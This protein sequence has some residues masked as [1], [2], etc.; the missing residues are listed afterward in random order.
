MSL[1]SKGLLEGIEGYVI[2]YSITDKRSF[3]KASELVKLI[4]E[5]FGEGE[6]TP[7]ALIGN[8]EDLVHYRVV[9]SKEGQR[10]ALLYPKCSFHECSAAQE[11]QNVQSA[12]QD[13]L[14]QVLNSKV[15]RR[16]QSTFS[17]LTPKIHST[18]RSSAGNST[19]STWWRKNPQNSEREV[20]QDRTFTM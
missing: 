16:R 18:R 4:K 6:E 19:L 15:Q 14:C 8:K 12:F 17:V 20:R 9:C 1:K 3:V 7:V 13:F 2:V 5:D 11:A 10:V